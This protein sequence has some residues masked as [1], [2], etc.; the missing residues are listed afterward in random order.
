MGEVSTIGVDLAKSPA[1]T[2]YNRYNRWS[3]RRLWQYS[4]FR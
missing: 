3:R 2:I 1:T 4:S